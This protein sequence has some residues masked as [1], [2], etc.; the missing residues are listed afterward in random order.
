MLWYLS[1]SGNIGFGTN[2]DPNVNAK[3]IPNIYHKPKG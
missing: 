3:E 1:E 2:N